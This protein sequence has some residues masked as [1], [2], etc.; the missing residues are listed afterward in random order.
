MPKIF[1]L[2]CFFI[3]STSCAKD[4]IEKSVQTVPSTDA[5]SLSSTYSSVDFSEFNIV[6]N[7]DNI[8]QLQVRRESFET[9]L[10]VY[11]G[12][13]VVLDSSRRQSFKDYK[14]NDDLPSLLPGNT[15]YYSIFYKT[16][17]MDSSPVRVKDFEI[18]TLT[19]Q[20]GMLQLF[21]E[22]IEYTNSIK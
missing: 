9:P 19:Y 12:E 18:T 5:V 11:D 2:L 7:W 15:Y 1:Y 21:N 14:I 4:Y 13:L 20:Q 17:S 22:L 10:T 6:Y 8:L 3:L 16:D